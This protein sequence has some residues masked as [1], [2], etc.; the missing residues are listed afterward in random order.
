MGRAKQIVTTPEPQVLGYT[1]DLE[2]KEA[3]LLVQLLHCH[4]TGPS[5]TDSPRDTLCNLAYRLM[6]A[7]VKEPEEYGRWFTVTNRGKPDNLYIS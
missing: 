6:E 4:L 7:G 1:L 3:D 2:P 5:G